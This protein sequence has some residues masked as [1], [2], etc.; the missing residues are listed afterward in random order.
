[1]DQLTHGVLRFDRFG[2]DLTQGFLR[3][4]ARDID[5]RPKASCAGLRA[6]VGA[7]YAAPSN[8]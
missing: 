8:A 7:R 2:L 5:L 4:G 1:M 3:A 6:S